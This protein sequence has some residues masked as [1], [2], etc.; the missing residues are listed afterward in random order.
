MATATTRPITQCY[1]LTSEFR[2]YLEIYSVSAEFAANAFSS[3]KKY[4]K[5]ASVVV[6][7]LENKTKKETMKT[8]QRQKWKLLI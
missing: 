2:V 5:L 4:I 3:K 6:Q 7:V 8:Q 1:S